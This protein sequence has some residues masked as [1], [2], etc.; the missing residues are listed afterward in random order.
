M[1]LKMTE[2]RFANGARKA[3]TLKRMAAGAFVACA[4]GA[5]A[6]GVAWA[7]PG[8]G[9]STTIIAGPTLLGEVHFKSKSPMNE[10]QFKTKGF[11]DVY[12]VHNRIV[13]GGHTGW[14]S[15]PGPSLIS[16]VSGQATEYHDDNPEGIVHQA[17][18]AF[19]DEGTHAHIVVNEG[20]TDLVLVAFQI[21]PFGAPRRI[22]Q[23]AP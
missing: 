17:G 3:K 9:V 13:P 19:V 23:P 16:V 7:T 2:E 11:S 5:V 4:F 14:H 18:T 8:Q 20:D 15:H 12:V 1:L 21:L 6:L 22:D 10:V